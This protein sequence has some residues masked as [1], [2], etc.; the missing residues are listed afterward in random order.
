[1]LSNLLQVALLEAVPFFSYKVQTL[2]MDKN[3]LKKIC[4]FTW[5]LL[6][7]NGLSW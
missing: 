1:M 7:L 3:F 4:V 2:Y 6:A 5:T